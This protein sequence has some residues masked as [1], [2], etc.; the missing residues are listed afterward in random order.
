M[1]A[2]ANLLQFGMQASIGFGG[3]KSQ[4]G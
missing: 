4:I 1:T 3:W 2:I